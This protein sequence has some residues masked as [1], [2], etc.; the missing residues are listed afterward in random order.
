MPNLILDLEVTRVDLVDEGCNSEAYIKLYKRKEQSITMNFEE[1]LAKM[2]PEHAEVVRAE[3]AKAKSEVPEAV[4]VELTKVKGDLTIAQEDVQKAKKTAEE[5]TAKLEVIEKAKESK[6]DFEEV[7]KGL[8]P[9]VQEIMKSLKADK[10]A[11]EAK[12]I[13]AEE[14]VKAA[15]IKKIT[16]EAIAKAKEFKALPVEE[17]KLVEVI[18][19]ASPEVMEVLKALSTAIEAGVLLD[20]TGLSKG[21]GGDQDAWEKIE[22]KADELVVSEKITKQKAIAKV[23][24][25]NPDMYKEYLKG[26]TN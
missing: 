18:K 10:E 22:K 12:Q 11:A 25:E 24:K 8:D 5:A 20:E 26:G 1:V 23:I 21:K 17:A 15:N 4:T 19:S 7:I 16:D 13:A 6:V 2:K 9:A 14:I 3:I